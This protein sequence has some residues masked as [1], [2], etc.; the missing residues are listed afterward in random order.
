MRRERGFTL[1]ELMIVV[2]IIGVLAAIAIPNFISMQSRAKE[3]S[4]KSNMH[5]VQLASEDYG[6]SNDGTYALQASDVLALIPSY[7]SAGLQNPFDHSTGVNNAWADQASWTRPL[8]TGASK[9]GVTVYGDSL[10][11]QYQVVGRGQK[12]DMNLV[13]SSGTQ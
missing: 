11:A 7:G 12:G 1:I 2:V 8:V 6:I 10:G 4:T 13:L 5:T 3:G 9:P